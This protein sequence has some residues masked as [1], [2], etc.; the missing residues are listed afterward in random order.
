MMYVLVCVLCGVVLCVDIFT[1]LYDL[2]HHPLFL[3]KWSLSALNP[4]ADYLSW[5]RAAIS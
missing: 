3:C 5:R 1:Y 4:T 2:Y